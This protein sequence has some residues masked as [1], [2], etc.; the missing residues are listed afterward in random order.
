M[1]QGDEAGRHGGP[2][3][4]DSPASAGELVPN[5]GIWR[6][7][8]TFLAGIVLSGGMAWSSYV[9]TAVTQTQVLQMIQSE[10]PYLRDRNMIKAQ[11]ANEQREL[12]QMNAKLDVLLQSRSSLAMQRGDR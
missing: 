12:D 5:G 3:C 2:A 4:L 10:D 9:R 8:T 1:S 7:V 11:L 6:Y